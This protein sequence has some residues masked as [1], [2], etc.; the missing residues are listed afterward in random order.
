M[1]KTGIAVDGPVA[2]AIATPYLADTPVA[3]QLLAAA[4]GAGFSIQRLE[5]MELGE[6]V[7]GNGCIPGAM[8]GPTATSNQVKVWYR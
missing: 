8:P 1:D 4:P 6:R 3:A 5:C 2:D 7:P